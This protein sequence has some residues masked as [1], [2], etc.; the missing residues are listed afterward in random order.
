LLVQH[1]PPWDGILDDTYEWTM[2]LDGVQS[3]QAFVILFG[4][5]LWYHSFCQSGANF[6]TYCSMD[7]AS[8]YNYKPI[9]YLGCHGFEM[10][11]ND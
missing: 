2:N 6:L 1:P 8:K 11:L 4:C 7:M 5:V 10:K 3:Q 9:Y